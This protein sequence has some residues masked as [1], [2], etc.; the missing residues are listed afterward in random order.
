MSKTKKF[1]GFEVGK[2]GF[3]KLTNTRKVQLHKIPKKDW[4]TIVDLFTNKRFVQV[5]ILWNKYSV[6]PEPLCTGCPFGFQ[7][8]GEHMPVLCA[9]YEQEVKE[10][11]FDPQVKSEED[12]PE[13]ESEVESPRVVVEEEK[14][15]RSSKSNK[16]KKED[17]DNKTNDDKKEAS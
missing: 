1:K 17:A 4:K 13:I 7:T 12:Q 14:K 5:I 9:R 6:T 3:V 11:V 15:P 2:S 10:G 8:I 16:K